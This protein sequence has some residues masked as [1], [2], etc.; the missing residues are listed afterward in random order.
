VAHFY[1]ARNS[2]LLL[3]SHDRHLLRTTVDSF[4]IVADGGVQEFNG[5][6]ED[7]REWLTNRHTESHANS[8]LTVSVQPSWDRKQQRRQEAQER[9][10]LAVLRRPL[11]KRLAE[12]ETEME[13]ARAR[14]QTLAALIADPTLY[15]DARRVERQAVM[16]E[17]GE[18]A[19]RVDE[20]E[21][22]WL[23]LQES[24]E[25]LTS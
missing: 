22:T 5:D 9:Q 25:G 11:E 1:S 12:V 3:V 17:Q 13:Q 24:L 21:E 15:G 19:K 4:W 20:M 2:S 6:L 16:T 8:T 23:S 14:M 10:R 18:L 7:Y